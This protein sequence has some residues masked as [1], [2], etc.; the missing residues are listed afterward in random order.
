MRNRKLLVQLDRPPIAND[1]TAVVVVHK[2]HS[3]HIVPRLWVL[4]SQ[5][6]HMLEVRP[7]DARITQLHLCNAD[8]VVQLRLV[9][10]PLHGVVVIIQSVVREPSN[11]QQVA[12]CLKRRRRSR[13][14]VRQMRADQLPVRALM[15]QLTQ[16]NRGWSRFTVR[17]SMG[18][19]A[20]KRATTERR[21]KVE[22]ECAWRYPPGDIWPRFS[23]RRAS[24]SRNYF[25]APGAEIPETEAPVGTGAVAGTMP[26]F[27]SSAILGNVKLPPAS[28]ITFT[29]HT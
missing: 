2:L 19:D 28:S 22:A 4:L 20:K 15:G 7:R 26:G 24:L 29:W 13:R 21:L 5:L 3:A 8:L 23:A 1:R 10:A 25:V 12:L 18:R 14:R 11:A 17:L 16:R 9:P 6:Q 27:N